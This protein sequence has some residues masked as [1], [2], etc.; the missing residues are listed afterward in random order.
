MNFHPRGRNETAQLFPGEIALTSF[1]F[2]ARFGAAATILALSISLNAQMSQ[3]Q[4]PS[5]PASMPSA[6]GRSGVGANPADNP[7]DSPMAAMNR[8]RDTD[9]VKKMVKGN[10]AEV[11]AGNLA[12]KNGGSDEVKK[13]GQKM[14][15]DHSAMLKDVTQLAQDLNIKASPEPSSK[16]RAKMAKMEALTGDAFDR[17]YVADMVKDHKADLADIKDESMNGANPQVKD[18]AAKAMPIVQGHLEM[19]ESIQKNMSGGS[20]K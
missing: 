19:I 15:D 17:A 5:N 12:V 7:A 18:A 14:V 4:M 6:S 2:A 1:Q 11:D 10:Q 9:F 8:E 16:D 3:P 20:K 13:F